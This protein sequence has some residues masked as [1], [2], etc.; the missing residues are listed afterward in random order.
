V[1]CESLSETAALEKRE[2]SEPPSVKVPPTA[3]A[4]AVGSSFTSSMVIV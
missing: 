1:D 2:T 3:L 4:D